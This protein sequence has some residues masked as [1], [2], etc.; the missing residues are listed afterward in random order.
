MK[1]SMKVLKFLGVVLVV[2]T[3]PVW[4]PTLVMLEVVIIPLWKEVRSSL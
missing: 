3:S 2:A 4:L 1:I